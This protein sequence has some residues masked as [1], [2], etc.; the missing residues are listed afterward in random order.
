MKKAFLIFLA[1]GWL[2]A[3]F[4]ATLSYPIVD[5]NQTHAYDDRQAVEFP[6]A[7]E[8]YFGQDG[9]YGARS[10][11]YKD[12]GDGTVTDLV[13]GLMW[14]KTPIKATYQEALDGAETCEVGGYDDWRV[15]SIKEIYSLMQFNG[16]D[17][18]PNSNLTEGLIPF[19][20]RSVFDFEY[21]DPREGERVI[22]SQ[23][24]TTS[25]NVSPIMTGQ[26]SFFGL[27]LADGRIKAYPTQSR[28]EK[29]FRA[30]YTR[31]N[32]AY[33]KNEFRDHGDGTITDAATGLMW[34]K[35]DSVE[36][37]DWPTALGYA[38]QM[39]FAG[40]SDW[41]LPSAKE[42]QSIIDYERSPGKTDSA[43][44]D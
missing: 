40:H 1:S 42:L 24:V 38:E 35:A 36:G 20:D 11:S 6:K 37:M 33:G 23:F 43:A 12:N 34:M 8:R 5:S 4:G 28:R 39:E 14:T 13:T 29:K 2:V 9:Q 25:V 16:L 21:G 3:S 17:P 32:V 15:P 31:G 27:N 30:L 18:D 22:D 10:P 7:G 44:I 41:R 26:E 19:I